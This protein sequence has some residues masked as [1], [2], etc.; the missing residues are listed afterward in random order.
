MRLIIWL[1]APIGALAARAMATLLVAWAENTGLCDTWLSIIP[2][3]YADKAARSAV[4]AAG[5]GDLIAS[6][7]ACDDRAHPRPLEND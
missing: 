2:L 7:A 3:P 1:A 4:G 5:V 6:S